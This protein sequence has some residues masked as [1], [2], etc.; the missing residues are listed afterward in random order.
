[1]M[2]QQYLQVLQVMDPA[3]AEEIEAIVMDQETVH[4]LD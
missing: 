1:M 4:Q 3:L 2:E